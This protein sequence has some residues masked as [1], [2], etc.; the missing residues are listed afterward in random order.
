MTGRRFTLRI[1]AF[2]GG[3]A[4]MLVLIEAVLRIAPVLDGTYAADPNKAW[5]LH[6]LVAHSDYTYSTGWNAGNIHHGHVNNYGYVAPFD[7]KPGSAG[8]VVIGDSYVESLMNDYGETL[9]GALNR[10]LETDQVVMPFGMSG[11]EL[12]HYLGTAQMI[13]KHFSPQWAVVVITANDYSAGFSADTGYYRWAPRRYPPIELVPEVRRSP[14]AKFVR[15]LAIVRYVRGNLGFRMG[16]LIHLHRAVDSAPRT[17]CTPAK[18]SPLDQRLT[19]QFIQAL[20]EAL[21][22][23]PPRVI[24]VFDSNRK[25]IYAGTPAASACPTVD[26][27]A[28]TRLMRLAAERGMRV[29]DSLPVFQRHYAA[30]HQ[31]VDYLPQDGHWNPT[32]HR[33]VAQEVAQVINESG[34]LAAG[35]PPLTRVS[36]PTPHRH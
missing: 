19:E 8:I 12:P 7:Y 15:S 34:S 30:T 13:G 36:R 6:R 18:L 5:P 3:M 11:A 21:G 33:L 28:R 14:F 24:L 2:L 31:H 9:Q 10:Y 32:A 26:E 25:A 23:L 29:I 17:A 16:D 35:Y 1:A 20:P 22:L 4:G 27:L